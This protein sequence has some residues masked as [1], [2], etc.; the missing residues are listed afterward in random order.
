MRSLRRSLVRPEKDP[1]L[2]PAPSPF[3]QTTSHAPDTR[4]LGT[5]DT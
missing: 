2:E 3:E 4:W 5:L 1:D